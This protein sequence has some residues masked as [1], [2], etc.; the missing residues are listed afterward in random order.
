MDETVSKT[1]STY[2]QLVAESLP[3]FLEGLYLYG[4]VALD[5]Y[6]PGKSDID[7][8]AISRQRADPNELQRLSRIHRML[9]AS[10]P[11]ANLSGIY[12]S[13]DDV[14]KNR[15]Q[16]PPFP[17]VDQNRFHE[18]GLYELNEVTWWQLK[19]KSV[20]VCGK[21]QEEIDLRIGVR[22]LQKSITLNAK[23][24]WQPWIRRH[25]R[26]WS[27]QGWALAC[28]P[29]LVEWG[30]TTV[31]RQFYTLSTGDVTSKTTATNYCL[32]HLP[33]RHHRL[34]NEVL[35]IRNGDSIGPVSFSWRRKNAAI[36]YMKYVYS[37]CEHQ[38]LFRE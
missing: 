34:L 26:A 24:Y 13:W 17:Y 35:E 30:V 3:N 5:D 11:R 27:Y 25:S 21:P 32:R 22:Q 14:G 29:R 2:Q 20:W 4:S 36:D 1:L 19:H 31:S 38:N 12:V 23:N 18:Q 7:F 9:K 10:H 37:E 28:L 15:Q 6:V 33:T 8:I 16:I